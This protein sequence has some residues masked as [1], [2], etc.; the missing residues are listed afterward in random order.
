MSDNS[1]CTV[2][3]IGQVIWG[4][5]GASAL[6]STR[7][8]LF[9]ASVIDRAIGYNANVSDGGW[10]VAVDGLRNGDGSWLVDTGAHCAELHS[11]TLHTAPGRNGQTIEL[12]ITGGRPSSLPNGRYVTLPPSV[13]KYDL[14]SAQLYFTGIRGAHNRVALEEGAQ[15]EAGWYVE[16]DSGRRVAGEGEVALAGSYRYLPAPDLNSAAIAIARRQIHIESDVDARWDDGGN[17]LLDG[18]RHIIERYAPLES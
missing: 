15:L 3:D 16:T 7:H 12:P 2:A 1:Y 18:L 11:A 6:P 9:A 4:R 10:W 13:D 17:T 8:A 14:T 5:T